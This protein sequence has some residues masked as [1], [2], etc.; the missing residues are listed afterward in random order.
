MA[1]GYVDT[2]FATAGSKVDVEI[3]GERYSAE[4]QDKPLYDPAGERMRS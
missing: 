1:M 3:L 4:I 2:E